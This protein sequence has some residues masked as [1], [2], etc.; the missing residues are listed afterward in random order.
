MY[1]EETPYSSIYMVVTGDGGWN[2]SLDILLLFC[3]RLLE[4]DWVRG[5]DYSRAQSQVLFGQIKV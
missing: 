1:L 4:M 2:P 5:E 3:F